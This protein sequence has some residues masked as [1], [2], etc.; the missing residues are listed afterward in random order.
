[1]SIKNAIVGNAFSSS[2]LARKSQNAVAGDQTSTAIVVR[3]NKLIESK[4]LLSLL[5][6]RFVL[7]IVSKIQREDADFHLYRMPVLDFVRFAGLEKSDEY[8]TR[9]V[10]MANS[11]TKRNLGIRD[12]FTRK[13]SFF[14]WF[15][16][17]DYK[18]GE[19]VIEAILHPELKPYLL[20]LKEQYTAITLE[21]ALLLRSSYA[22]RIYD[23]LKQYQ[24]IGNRTI[25]VTDL[26]EMLEIRSRE[27]PKY[28]DFR[29]RVLETAQREINNK[30]DISFDFE[31]VKDG[32]KITAIFFNIHTAVPAVTL[33]NREE[34][35]EQARSAFQ[36]LL[37]HGVAEKT[38]RALVADYD[39]ERIKWHIASYEKRRKDGKASGIGWLVDGI[40]SDYRP[41]ASIFEQ[42][43]EEKRARIQEERTRQASIEA[44]V[45]RIKHACDEENRRA[46]E[47]F[48]DGLADPERERLDAEFLT[49]YGDVPQLHKRLENEGFN[50]S[51][52]RSLYF[53][54]LREKYPT[55]NQDYYQYAKGKGASKEVLRVL[56]NI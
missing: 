15:H 10:E 2:F 56:Q 35:D 39:V 12:E 53:I 9:I 45:E 6:R 31:P 14:P 36:A 46:G 1:M 43:E 17:I 40:R 24:H 55:Q 41:Q 34:T 52:V 8:Y 47:L 25:M 7:W 3:H 5:E 20:Q 21:Y 16:R 13:Y 49:R 18:W 42:E 27:Y 19:G 11:L 4:H 50:S 30:T 23:L 51:L 33:G 28:A 32:K 48:L 37:K 29:R 26:R 44:E 54:F 22:H 38:A